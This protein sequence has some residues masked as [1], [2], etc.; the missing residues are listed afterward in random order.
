MPGFS[1]AM[2]NFLMA[3]DT[4][5]PVLAEQVGSS[6]SRT[7]VEAS[8]FG[9]RAA[10]KGTKGEII[11]TPGK[12]LLAFDEMSKT[13]T[14]HMFVETAAF[15]IAGSA[16]AEGTISAGQKEQLIHELITTK[17]SP[18][19]M[20]ALK[21]SQRLALQSELGEFG[22]KFL[23]MRATTP[24][25]RYL[26]PF[27]TTPANLFRHGIRKSPIGML[28]IIWKAAHHGS[29]KFGFSNSEFS[30]KREGVV[31]DLAEQLLAGGVLAALIPFVIPDDEDGLPR[32]TGTAPS[33]WGERELQYRAAPPMSVR[34]SDGTWM[35]YSGVEPGAV[36]IGVFVDAIHNFHRAVNSNQASV[37]LGDAFA[38]FSGQV[39]NL[40][41]LRGIGDLLRIMRD[42]VK[43][44]VRYATN[45]G[46]SFV[47]NVVRTGFRAADEGIRQPQIYGET[48][49]AFFDKSVLRT[50]QFGLPHGGIAPPPKVDL[51]GNDIKK[52]SWDSP[53]TDWGYRM[54][55]PLRLYKVQLGLEGNL[56]RM[57]LNWNNMHPDD[58]LAPRQPN[59]WAQ[60]RGEKMYMSDEEYHDFMK[61]SG[62]LALRM[63]KNVKWNFDKPTDRDRK[64]LAKMVNKAR[65]I[66][67]RRWMGHL[68]SVKD[69][70]IMK[71]LSS[72]R[73]VA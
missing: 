36:T 33:G 41:L 23:Q 14:S 62:E 25:M 58:I 39:G 10:I 34:L 56:N 1:Q 37:V 72:S 55:S 50:V 29:V 70:R 30:Y 32:I 54:M 20:E 21:E 28:N 51:W 16:V 2:Q 8:D 17:G 65:N 48:L 68:R 38:S 9:I 11:R 18:A 44:S 57:M 12:L 4:S 43:G 6:E 63:A 60:M 35:S 52:F 69:D 26:F 24:F 40:P 61:S 64:L 22:K 53:L 19:W 71:I 49:D 5:A 46:A 31:K 13:L 45:F 67:R 7:R 73:K 3:F 66:E 42:P 27:V 47:P 15:R 59:P